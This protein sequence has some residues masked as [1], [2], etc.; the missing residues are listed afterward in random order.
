MERDPYLYGLMAMEVMTMIVL[1][2]AMP[3]VYTPYLLELLELMAGLV[4]LTRCALQ[5]WSWRM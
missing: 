1:L 4:I 5:K 3:P 2:M